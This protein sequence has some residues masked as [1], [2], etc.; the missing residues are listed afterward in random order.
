MTAPLTPYVGY[1][2]EWVVE[3]MLEAEYLAEEE[4]GEGDDDTAI[5]VAGKWEKLPLPR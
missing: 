3:L 1:N 2:P 4:S 5:V